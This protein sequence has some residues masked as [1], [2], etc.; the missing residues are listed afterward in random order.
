MNDSPTPLP[1]PVQG[2]L[3]NEIEPTHFTKPSIVEVIGNYTNLRQSGRECR[4]RG[5]AGPT[6]RGVSFYLT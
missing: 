3:S 6:A 2:G 1:S 4:G 5:S